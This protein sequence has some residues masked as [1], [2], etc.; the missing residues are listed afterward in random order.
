MIWKL[1]MACLTASSIWGYS[2]VGR[3]LRSQCRSQGFESPYLHQK[4]KSS[5]KG[6]FLLVFSLFFWAFPRC[7]CNILCRFA[8]FLNLNMRFRERSGHE[9]GHEMDT[10]KERSGISASRSL[11][12]DCVIIAR[13]LPDQQKSG[14]GAPLCPKFSFR[15]RLAKDSLPGVGLPRFAPWHRVARD[16]AILSLTPSSPPAN[17]PRS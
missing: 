4:A 2:S 12:R 1:S 15:P 5:P 14:A 13:I 16:A 10:K 3:A 11:H 8:V 9:N 17:L 7:I 6:C